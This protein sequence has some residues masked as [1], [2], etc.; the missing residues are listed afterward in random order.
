MT[1]LRILADDELDNVAGGLTC[2]DAL[3][4]GR[5]YG[6]LGIIYGNLGMSN[7]A[8]SNGSYGA[9]LVDGACSPRP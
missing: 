8:S 3:V 4:I 9:G 1:E 7:E 2:Q 5:F 6:A